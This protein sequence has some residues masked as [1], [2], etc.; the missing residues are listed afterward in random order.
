MAERQR[1]S[2]PCDRGTLETIRQLK[3]S[4]ENYDRLLNK[5]A[6]QYDPEA[7]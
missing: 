7:N 5:M 3:R 6:D 2:I 1:T 4:G